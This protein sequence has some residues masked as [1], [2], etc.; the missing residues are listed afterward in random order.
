[1][2]PLNT[3]IKD[4]IDAVRDYFEELIDV[5]SPDDALQLDKY[6]ELTQ[7]TKPLIVIS[8]HEIAET[9]RHLHE[10]LGKLAPEKDDPLRLIV[11]DLGDPPQATGG[12][13]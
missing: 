13:A 2:A 8:L 11:T 7:K 12:G 10:H 5:E 4:K 6:M 9:H 1:M 3:W